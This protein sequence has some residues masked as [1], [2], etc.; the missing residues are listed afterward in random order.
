M[1]GLATRG[2]ARHAMTGSNAGLRERSIGPRTHLLSCIGLQS[3]GNFAPGEDCGPRG[4]L[5][6]TKPAPGVAHAVVG[7]WQKLPSPT[8]A[9][10]SEPYDCPG[11][12]LSW[13]KLVRAP[14]PCPETSRCPRPPKRS[15][16]LNR[17]VLLGRSIRAGAWGLDRQPGLLPGWSDLGYGGEN[18]LAVGLGSLKMPVVQQS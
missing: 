8:G 14:W 6:S 3:S 5:T 16:S 18:D 13:K 10:T 2:A 7:R 4:A 15:S 17:A 12:G 11:Q 9:L 1:A